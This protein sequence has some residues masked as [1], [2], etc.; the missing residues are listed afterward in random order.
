RVPQGERLSRSY[1]DGLTPFAKQFNGKGV[2]FARILEGGAWQAPFAK[3]FTDAARTEVNRIASAVP[4]DVLIFVA[5]K[6]KVAN[7]CLGA[8]RLHVGEELG[9]IRTGEFQ[10]MWLTDPPLFEV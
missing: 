4:G 9:A 7:T 6:P 2:A 5:D 3:N 8:I 10:F 1:L